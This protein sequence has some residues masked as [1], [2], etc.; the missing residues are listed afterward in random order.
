[1]PFARYLPEQMGSATITPEGPFVAGSHAELKLTYTAGTFGIDDSGHLK[2]TWRTASDMAKPQLH[3]PAAANYTTVE[4]SNGAVLDV[5]VD[6]VNIRPWV[7]TLFIRVQRGYLREGDRITVHFG[8]PVQGSPGLRLQSNCERSFELKVFVDAFAAY[9]FTEIPA[10]PEIALIPGEPARWKAIWPTL[11]VAGEPFRLAIVAEDRWGNPTDQADAELL[12]RP[13]APIAGLPETVRIR[14]GDGPLVIEG[15]R[16]AAPGDLSLERARRVVEHSL[17]V[18]SAARRAG[19]R[20]CASS[21]ATCTGRARRPS[22][23]TPPPTILRMPATAP[24]STSRGTRPTTSR[25]PTP[26]GR[27]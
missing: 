22:A 16:A 26:S 12:L 3:D 21:G 14:R 17:L 19:Q 18:Q 9:E 13:S 15:L 2:I 23:P 27:S 6:R 1:M 25:S 24:S 10:S 5:R 11:A 4:A 8:N 7:N 20:S